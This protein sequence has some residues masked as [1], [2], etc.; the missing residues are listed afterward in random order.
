MFQ[1]LFWWILLWKTLVVDLKANGLW[2]FNPYSDGYCSESP[3]DWRRWQIRPWVSILILMDI[4]LK[5]TALLPQGLTVWCFNPYSDGYCSESRPL[6]EVMEEEA[7]FQSLFWWILLWKSTIE[8]A[9]VKP[10][11]VSILILMDIA[12][13]GLQLIFA[14][15]TN[16]GFNPYSDGYCSERSAVIMDDDINALFQSLFW[17]ILLWKA[18]VREKKMTFE[19]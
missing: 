11:P 15:S 5:V 13:K 4:A 14:S 7:A 17:W 16:P 3:P 8:K 10:I 2:S 6:S 12:L 18:C 9:A 19:D 1:S